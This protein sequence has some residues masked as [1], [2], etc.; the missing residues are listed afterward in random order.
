MTL[1]LTLIS[2]HHLLEIK[3]RQSPTNP[4]CDDTVANESLSNLLR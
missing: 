4:I 3:E 2:V 1:S